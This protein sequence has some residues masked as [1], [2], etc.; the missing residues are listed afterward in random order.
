VEA[1]AFREDLYYRLNVVHITVPPLRERAEDIPLLA[2]RLLEKLGR[3]M[4]R[5]I[6]GISP[7]ALR[8][9][10]GY[11]FPGNVRELENLL[12][13]ACIL[14]G[15][16]TIEAADLDLRGV[17]GGGQPATLQEIERRS[18]LSALQ[19]WEGNRTRAARELGISRRSLQ[20]KLK[21]FGAEEA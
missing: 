8:K 21:A 20:Y 13:R 11:P 9:L 17:T 12:E 16:G 4:G 2:G 1:G 14:A 7:E 19:R 15:T 10:Q 6:E 18:I 5:R 3:R